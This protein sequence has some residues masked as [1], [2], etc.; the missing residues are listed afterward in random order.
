MINQMG[1]AGYFLIVQDMVNWAK[2]NGVPVGPGRG[3]AAG[4]VV[5]YILGITNLDPLRYGLIFER[6]LN[7]ERVSM[8]DIDIDFGDAKRDRVIEYIVQ[9]YGADKV[10][11]IITF[12]TMAAKAAIRDVGRALAIPYS[13][14]DRIAK[15]IPASLDMTVERALRQNPELQ[16]EYETNPST[17]R[18]LDVAR[19]IE[20]MPRHSSMHAAGVVIGPE[21]L[22]RLVPLQKTSDGHVVTQFTKEIVEDIGLL[23]MDILGLRTLTILER[24]RENILSSRGVALDMDR[25][26]LGDEATYALLSQGNTIGVFQLESDGMRAILR[27]LQ[28]NCIEDVIAVNALYRP[29][30]LGSG[31]VE[32]F[33]NRK[34]GRQAI[35]YA[36]PWLEDILRET[37]GVILYQEQVMQIAS[38]LANFT[39]GQ[40]DV[41]R[42]AMGKKKPDVLNAKRQ[43]F[44]DGAAGNGIDPKI[45]EHLFDLM[46]SFAG[47]GFNK[48]HAAAYGIVSYQTAYLKT[49]YPL[50]Y[51]AAFLSSVIDNRDK[52]AFYLQECKKMGIRILP[53]DINQSD[54]TFTIADGGIRFGLG[55]I[56]N[57]GGGAVR[58]IVEARREGSFQ[59]AFDFCQRVDTNQINRRMVEN[60]VFAGCFDSLGLTRRQAFT[61]LSDC[62]ELALQV[63]AYANMNQASLFGGEEMA[64]VPPEPPPPEEY[65][66]TDKMNHEKDVL[67]FF[68]SSNP[69]DTYADIL[70]LVR[71]VESHQL[72]QMEEDAYIQINGILDDMQTRTSRRGE[73]YA[74]M[75]LEDGNGRVEAL[76]FPADFKK[77]HANLQRLDGGNT[78]VVLE[79]TV[80][81]QEELPRVIVRKIYPIPQKLR[82]MHVRLP[83]EKADQA[84]QYELISILETFPGDL[85][86]VVH[87][88]N[89]RAIMLGDRYDVAASLELKREIGRIY[90]A[91]RVWFA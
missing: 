58:S 25:L 73:Q 71:T 7:P 45:S 86:V 29:G 49:H 72:D 26:H 56:K 46:E 83:T 39:L 62:M 67:G 60:L 22:D 12:G 6:F 50:E 51:M 52:V 64:I 14:T 80:N 36:H 27:D 20:G 43:L 24:A 41:L 31:M 77:N 18:L 44:V 69:L 34:H 38:R 76:L 89:R 53:P 9:K 19:A 87:L 88:P 30:P 15:Q 21:R 85:N 3:S 48:S 37:Y 10:A 84:G 1:F 23:K 33:I 59:H 17:R 2:E 65:A 68:V 55:A 75:T 13:E 63:K 54:E 47:Y 81:K 4:S 5:S 28:P 8:P 61:Y 35:V 32:D 42:R 57:V 40:A 90:G 66:Q 16:A 78:P 82:E 74:R 91:N 70:P 79:G 11:Q